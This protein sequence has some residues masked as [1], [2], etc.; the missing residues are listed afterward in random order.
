M[1]IRQ[2]KVVTSTGSIVIITVPSALIS[3]KR[4][5]KVEAVE[6][7]SL[8]KM[9]YD[10]VTIALAIPN[11][12]GI[13]LK[14]GHAGIGGSMRWTGD[15][16]V[17]EGADLVVAFAYPP[18]GATCYIRYITAEVGEDTGHTGDAVNI[19]Q[20]Y[21][22]GRPKIINIDGAADALSIPVKPADNYQY[23]IIWLAGY[24]D[25]TV[26]RNI[27]WYLTDG[28]VS[29]SSGGASKAASTFVSLG[30]VQGG[31]SLNMYGKPIS[32]SMT[33]WRFDADA[34]AAGKHLYVR[35]QVLEYAV[36]GQ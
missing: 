29:V 22:M 24:H 27:T 1:Q 18:S 28:V 34:L 19:V 5:L 2:S 33:W 8:T 9:V 6:L 23:E 17:P 31:S 3:G 10:I 20:S 21:P 32:T 11:T 35:G 7:D 15:K 26:N 25:D 14:I 4:L 36:G 30:I 12:A 13:D 16:L